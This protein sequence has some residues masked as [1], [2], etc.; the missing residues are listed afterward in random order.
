MGRAPQPDRHCDRRL[1]LWVLF[2]ATA[3]QLRVLPASREEQ[4]HRWSRLSVPLLDAAGKLWQR[5]VLTDLQDRTNFSTTELEVLLNH[6]T[7]NTAH[8]STDDRLDR[9][10]FLKCLGTGA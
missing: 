4:C 5:R 8:D 7:R 10:T 3:A 2:Q 9:A 1:G 6:F